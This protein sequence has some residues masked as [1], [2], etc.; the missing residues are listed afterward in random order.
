MNLSRKLTCRWIGPWRVVEIIS[1][2]LCTIFPIGTWCLQ[3][4]EVRT[5]T[6]RIRKIDP[7]YSQPLGEMID[8]D[9]LSEE[10]S[11]VE[12][13]I[14]TSPHPQIN[15]ATRKQATISGL[16]TL[17]RCREYPALYDLFCVSMCV[18]FSSFSFVLFLVAMC[19]C[20]KY[21]R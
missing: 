4:K 9:L 11:E 8:L 16:K 20:R 5:L 6:S 15:I 7:R 10:E 14:L 1:P 3:K 17:S 2:S 12:D 18:T 21:W 13:I 19:Q